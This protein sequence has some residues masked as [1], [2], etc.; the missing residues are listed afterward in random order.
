MGRD[1]ITVAL[2]LVLPAFM[3]LLFGYALTLDVDHVR[4]AVCDLDRTAASRDLISR[5]SR[6]GT[7]DVV[8]SGRTP[9]AIERL[10]DAGEAR[11]GLVIPPGYGRDLAAARG[12][13]VELLID[14]SDSNTA[15][16]AQGYA[17]VI[18]R[19]RGTEVLLGAIGPG[20][21]AAAPIEARAR[22]FFNP[23][24][25]SAVFIVP[26]LLGILLLIATVLMTAM[27]I[28]RE[29]ERGT[30]EVL[31]A[32][33]VRPVE[34][35]LGK[36]APYV[37]VAF[38]DLAIAIAVMVAGFGIP[39]VGS[40]LVLLGATA[41]FVTASLGYGLLISTVARSQQI[42]WTLGVLTTL[43]PSFLLSGFVFPIE[44][45]APALQA[46]TRLIPARYYLA[47]LRGVL[48]KGA[49]TADLAPHAAALAVFAVAMPA[50]AAARFRKRLG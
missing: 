1:P 43:L 27:S 34:L 33:P 37:V 18:A 25:R 4:L 41:L 26:G 5:F 15:R 38:A 31:I 36:T 44:N 19:Q 2:L 7:F 14:G 29:R 49:S 39:F 21:A 13:A 6:A 22:G 12:A 8:A 30:F 28:V 3:L 23:E 48:L 17:A 50:L 16:V 47:A 24:L 10:L 20:A 32:T 42:A 40:P 35:I 9:R 11:A 45:M 46:V